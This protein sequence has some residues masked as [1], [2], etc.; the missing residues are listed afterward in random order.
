MDFREAAALLEAG[1]VTVVAHQ[2]VASA[3]EAAVAARRLGYPVVVKGLGPTLLHKTD[4]HVVYPNLAGET[5][6]LTAY[7]EVVGRP[8]VETVVVQAMIRDGVEMLVGAVH[9]GAFGHAVM[10]ASGGIL[11]E[12]LHDVALRLAPVT[13]GAVASMLHELRGTRLLHGFRGATLLDE[14]AL[15]ET[16]LR[17][18]E[19]VALCPEIVELDL[20]PVIVTADGAIVVDA[21][22]RLADDACIRPFT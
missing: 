3:D 19:L 9:Q 2:I 1:G 15:A 17:V 20:N 5:A 8:G 4:A 14:A 11:V 13:S 7:R 12:L 18:S 22:I 10:C 21:R 16:V 6:V